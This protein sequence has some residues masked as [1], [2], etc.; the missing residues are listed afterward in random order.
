MDFTRSAVSKSLPMLDTRL[1]S[2][3]PGKVS[4]FIMIPVHGAVVEYP[5]QYDSGSSARFELKYVSHNNVDMG[6]ASLRIN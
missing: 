5:S 3:G 4:R 6:H 2:Q 1:S